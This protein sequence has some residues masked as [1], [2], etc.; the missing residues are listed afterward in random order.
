MAFMAMTFG[1][2]V[3]HQFNRG[4]PSIGP[5]EQF[6]SLIHFFENKLIDLKFKLRPTRKGNPKVVIVA[7][8]EKSL[9]KLGRWQSWPREHYAHLL[10]QATKYGAKVVA[11]D[12]VFDY[13]DDNEGFKYIGALSANYEISHEDSA[14]DRY[15]ALLKE[16]MKESNTDWKLVKAVT[17][18]EAK[19]GKVILGYFTESHEKGVFLK[20]KRDQAPSDFKLLSPSAIPTMLSAEEIPLEMNRS[21][22]NFAVNFYQLEKATRHKGYFNMTPDQDGVMRSY[23]L[24]SRRYENFYPS[25]G[26]KAIKEYLGAFDQIKQEDS[27]EFYAQLTLQ[28]SNKIKVELD[29]FG[30]VNLNYYGPQNAFKTVSLADVINKDEKISYHY[31]SSLTQ[32]TQTSKAELFKDSIVLLGAT[33][34]GIFDVRN[35]PVQVDLPGVEAHATIISQFLDNTHLIHS[36]ERLSVLYI[37]LSTLGIFLFFIF[38]KKVGAVLGLLGLFT[39]Y[40]GIFYMDLTYFFSNNVLFQGMTFYLMFG[41]VH[42]TVTLYKYFTEVR[43]KNKIKDT[44]SHYVSGEV[45]KKMIEDPQSIK[46]GGESKELTVLFTDIADFTT[47]SER[48]PP[49]QLSELLNT[50]LSEMTDILFQQGGTLDKYIGDAIMGF[51]GA[52]IEYPDHARRA[53]LA[54]YQ[55][56]KKSAELRPKFKEQYDVDLYMR[57]GLNTGPMAVGNMGSKI[58][59]AYTALGD[60]VNLGA[61]LESINKVYGTWILVSEFTYEQVKDDFHFRLIDKVAVKGKETAVK[62]YEILGTK[63]DKVPYSAEFLETYGVALELYFMGEFAEAMKMFKSPILKDDKA[64]QE[65]IK[66]CEQLG[67]E[68]TATWTGIWVMNSK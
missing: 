29:N 65:F 31:N 15:R 6:F 9:Q 50:Y 17:D 42:L 49:R 20:Q 52:P 58:Q 24:V 19:G 8:D 26:F 67:H 22:G 66:R 4:G 32:L 16:A 13:P 30:R 63:G 7:I 56:Q 55:M 62:I 68:D 46:M 38:L 43:E 12:A 64:S 34:I 60:H 2:S 53:C 44:F 40:G 59:F 5:A 61:R 48:L 18:F 35:T 54:A 57:I 27:G 36:D 1:L 41:V 51:W 45:V 23:Q 21:V 25:L 39:V 11:F 3:F 47:F 28:N 10:Q 37:V 14:Q 33:A